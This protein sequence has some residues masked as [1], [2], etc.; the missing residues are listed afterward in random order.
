M[1]APALTA[2][3]GLGTDD[4]ERL[5]RL[6]DRQLQLAFELERLGREGIWAVTADD[7]RYPRG[8]RDRLGSQG[9]QILFGAGDIGSLGGPGLGVVGSRDA[10]LDAIDY[11]IDAGRQAARQGW[12]TVSGGAR[13]VDRAAM[14][15]AWESGGVVVAVVAEGVARTLRDASVRSAIRDGQAVV[16]SPYR[17]DAS[18]SV[19]NAM[20]RNRLIYGLATLTVVVSSAA[21]KGGTWAG[22]VEAIEHGWGPVYVRD[23]AGVA[24]GNG[25]LVDR[26]G[27]PLTSEQLGALPDLVAAA[28]PPRADGTPQ[29]VTMFEE[30]AAG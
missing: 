10:D 15:G 17:P 21:E 13:G 27:L 16:V 2:R 22:A 3:L 4:G 14:Q 18:F 29:Q 5:R 24:I 11:A 9:P 30:V 19:G 20:G 23:A 12:A 1:D 7:E 6:L 8:L 28:P 25:R 26:G